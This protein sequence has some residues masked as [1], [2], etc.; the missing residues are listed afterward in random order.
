MRNEGKSRAFELSVNNDPYY[1][2][3]FE[4]IFAGVRGIVEGK[5]S[6]SWGEWVSQYQNRQKCLIFSIIDCFGA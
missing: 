1:R 5:E 6:S 3:E 4:R 2:D